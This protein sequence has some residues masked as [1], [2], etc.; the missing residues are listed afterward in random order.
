MD[1][2]T[3]SMPQTLFLTDSEKAIFDGFEASQKEGWEVQDETLT[4][5]DTE[6]YRKIRLEL[7]RVH[8]PKLQDF[9]KKATEAK[10]SEEV[11]ELIANIELQNLPE[12]DLMQLFFAMGPDVLTSFIKVYLEQAKTDDDLEAACALT[13]IRHALLDSLQSL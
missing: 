10:N 4:F 5:Q 8:D 12:D 13:N 1:S 9:Q 2:P 3:P 11:E 7:L 6:E